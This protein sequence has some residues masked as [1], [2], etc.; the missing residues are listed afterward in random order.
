TKGRF[1]FQGVSD[2]TYTVEVEGISTLYEPVTQEVRVIYGASPPVLISLR[3]KAGAA[4]RSRANVVSVAES[5]QQVP[6]EARKEFEKGAEL[7]EKGRFQDAIERFKKA[8]AIFP[9]YLVAR[10]NLGVQYLKMGQWAEAAKQF[11][12]A[13][14]VNPKALNPQQNL[15][16][17][18][19][20]Q[21]KYA[22]AIEHLNQALSIDSSSPTAHLYAG[23]ASL[24]VDAI[25]QAE[26]ELST[27]LSLG[28]ADY[29]NAHFY[30]ALVYMKK[31]ERDP[32]V[33]ELR[34]YLEKLPNG[35]KAPRA[36]Q[37]L[38]RLKQ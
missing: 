1:S 18:L 37:L 36:R 24:G 29:S 7:S 9:N 5:D 22:Q 3:E 30:L 4:T 26:R 35:E 16:I 21:K 14:E 19:I 17:A 15:A 23:I 32:A 34:S 38:E 11:E 13:I 20:E 33:R 12:A 25:D 2:G 31:G 10:N 6:D 27:A 28:G 8:L